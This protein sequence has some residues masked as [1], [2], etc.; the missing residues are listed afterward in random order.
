MPGAILPAGFLSL[1]TVDILGQIILVVAG[2]PV[3]YGM[4]SG[5]PGLHLLHAS[6]YYLLLPLHP[7]VTTTSVSRQYQMPSGEQNR[8]F[9]NYRLHECIHSL[10]T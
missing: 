10:N 8:L 5:I 9:E 2:C 3:H 1:G 4:F 7:S 6:T